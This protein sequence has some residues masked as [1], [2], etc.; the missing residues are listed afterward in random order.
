MQ[1]SKYIG[2]QNYYQ[3][4]NPVRKYF[5]T[6]EYISAENCFNNYSFYDLFASQ[7][8]FDV[9]LS[10]SYIHIFEIIEKRV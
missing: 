6:M 7:I 2:T 5:H 3:E 4:G 8:P 10:I 1:E 9:Y